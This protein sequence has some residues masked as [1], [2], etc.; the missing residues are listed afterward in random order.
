MPRRSSYPQDVCEWTIRMA[1]EHG[2][3]YDSQWDRRQRAAVF[4]APRSRATTG[5]SIRVIR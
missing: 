4:D 1:F 5:S 3:E 2:R